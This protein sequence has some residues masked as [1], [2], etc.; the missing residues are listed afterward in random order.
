LRI[1]LVPLARAAHHRPPPGRP[2]RHRPPRGPPNAVGG[3][4]R[5]DVRPPRRCALD[6]GLPVF[7]LL[8]APVLNFQ[9]SFLKRIPVFFAKFKIKQEIINFLFESLD[10]KL[11]Q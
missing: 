3:R 11:W 7:T 5:R 1:H 9:L 4:L 8:L 10:I 2:G 6:K